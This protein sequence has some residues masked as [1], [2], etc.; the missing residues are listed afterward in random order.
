MRYGAADGNWRDRR[1]GPAKTV[2]RIR[3]RAVYRA[4]QVEDCEAPYDNL[5][6]KVHYP[7]DYG[8][9]FEERDT[10]FIPPDTSRA[11]FPV[12]IIMPG[13]NI[14][15]EAYGWIAQELAQ[16]GFAAVT[17]SW[18][19]VEMGERVGAS[20]GVA[21][22]ALRRDRYGEA[23]SCPALPAILRELERV[24]G[25]GL[26]AGHLDLGR[27]VL[28]GHS[29]GGTMALVNANSDWYP[30]VRGA[31]AYAAHTRGNLRLGWPDDSIMPLA[32]NLPLLLMGGT[33]DGV[34]AAS[35]YRYREAARTGPDDPIA[36]TFREG[37]SGDGGGRHL[38][39]VDSANHFSFVWPR[40]TTT[41]RPYL[42]RK[43]RGGGKRLRAYIAALTCNFC[44][45]VC[46]GDADSAATFRALCDADHPLA[47]VA[48]TK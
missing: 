7:C 28:G 27:I 41:G 10:G 29:A 36:R 39:I 34:I 23:P 9:S 48:E 12:V 35:S 32:R 19:T 4:A 30:G 46:M 16:A 25:D 26:L 31:F 21:L 22:E 44:R 42:D 17:Y 6:L 8:D 38:V 37:V 33:R 2:K 20:P 5:T 47:T 15:Q 24:H 13:V 45:Q 18:V 3:V 43:A 11:P 14:S 1:S 40:D